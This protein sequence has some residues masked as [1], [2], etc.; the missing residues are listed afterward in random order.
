[1]RPIVLVTEKVYAKGEDVFRS[2]G[3]LDVRPAATAELPLSESVRALRS[4]AVVVGPERYS[5]PL[6]AALAE[7]GGAGGAIIARFGVGC[8]G[9]D[10]AAARRLGVIVTNT[11]GVLEGSVAE[12]AIWLLG[13]L[14]RRVSGAE[15]RLRS[16]EFAGTAGVELCGK[17][18][19][20]LG[21]GAIGRRVASIAHFGLGMRVIAFGRRSPEEMREACARSGVERYT[22]DADALLGTS[23]AVSLHLAATAE[24][25]RFLDARRLSLLR[26]AAFLVN[27]A[28]GSLIDEVALHDVLLEG[29]IGGA[30]LDV[31]ETEPYRPAAPG[32]DLRTLSNVLLTPHIG[33]NTREANERMARASL[34]NVASFLTG[35]HA[36]LTRVD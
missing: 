30:A 3:A 14:A 18:L 27:T 26:P 1:M 35:D 2:S 23:D 12:H 8:D 20:I 16:G 24:T 11:P 34:G 7:A 29:R 17:T 32:K 36:A 19:G 13:N 4:R 5:D 10:L 33:S 21:L 25:R 22:R 15:A 6:Y 31:F 28:R 9:I